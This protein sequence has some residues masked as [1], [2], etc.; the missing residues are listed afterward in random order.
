M[1][2]AAIF[3][4]EGSQILGMG[5]DLFDRFF[6]RLRIADRILGYSLRTLCLEDP[7]RAISRA[8]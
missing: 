7:R 1:T 5:A 8:R 3:P 2:L 6:D 4:G